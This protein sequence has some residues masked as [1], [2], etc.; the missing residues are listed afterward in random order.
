MATSRSTSQSCLD[1]GANPLSRA[2]TVANK[3]LARAIVDDICT[4]VVNDPDHWRQRAIE[5]I[6][7]HLDVAGSVRVR[8]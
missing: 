7:L 4:N 2:E 6:A 1:H 5:E 3:L 8:P